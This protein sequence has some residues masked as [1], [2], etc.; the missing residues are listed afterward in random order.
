MQKAELE[1]IAHQLL[2]EGKGILAADESMKTIQKRFDSIHV[3]STEETRRSYRE[4]LFT[5]PNMEK[6]ISG[7]ILFDETIRQNSKNGTPLRDI[8]SQKGILPGIKVDEGT[9][10]LANFPNEK[11]TEG[12]DG[13]RE[14]FAE[15]R[16]LGAK[17]SKWRAVITIGD[18]IPTHTCIESN[19]EVLARYAALSQEAGIMP[20]VEPEVLMDGNH[21]LEQCQKAT[22]ATLRVVF[23]HLMNHRVLLEGMILKPNMVL[24][25]KQSSRQ[26]SVTE[27]AEATVSL[28]R[29]VVPAAVP[30]IAFLSGGQDAILAT[31]HLNAMNRIPDLPWKLTFSYSRALQGP[32]LKAWA[33]DESNVQIAQ[34]HF[35]HRALCNSA[36]SRAQYSTE[37]ETALQPAGV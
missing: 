32:A 24:P 13:L 12:L 19:A 9:Q 22:E 1:S 30:G 7:V 23:G 4:M 17:F 35:Y 15:Y 21:T 28:F 25:G 29:E 20:I 37:M 31:E 26:A 5:T 8:L 14:R 3:E 6:F 18:G 27:V 33:G 34:Q 36:A 16:N 10:E 11:I 2:A